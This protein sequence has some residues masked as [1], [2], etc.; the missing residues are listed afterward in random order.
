MYI[1]NN[2]IFKKSFS[3]LTSFAILL[4]ML[5]LIPAVEVHAA[6]SD[7][8]I[9]GTPLTSAVGSGYP[10]T[11]DD[12]Q[13]ALYITGNIT[14]SISYTGSTGTGS[15]VLQDNISVT[16]DI[17]VNG[18]VRLANG[19]T[20]NGNITTSSFVYVD[21]GATVNGNV[22]TVGKIIINS[23]TVNGT[24][25]SSG[26]Q[27]T[28]NGRV[29][30][31]VLTSGADIDDTNVTAT[32]YRFPHSA[33]NDGSGNLGSISVIDSNIVV[34]GPVQNKIVLFSKTGHPTTVNVQNAGALDG[35]L[36][37]DNLVA[38][39]NVSGSISGGIQVKG[40]NPSLHV[41][42]NVSGDIVVDAISTDANINYSNG[43]LT[44]NIVNNSHLADVAISLSATINGN[45]S[46]S[47]D[48]T[49]HGG[50][51]NGSVT[52]TGGTITM[53]IGS[54]VS[55][56][57]T[58]NLVRYSD[59][60]VDVGVVLADTLVYDRY[61]PVD[62]TTG[63][64]GT[65]QTTAPTGGYIYLT[66]GSS[67]DVLT[68]NNANLAPA[69]NNIWNSDPLNIHLQGTNTVYDVIASDSV[70]ITADANGVLN[71]GYFDMLGQILSINSGTVNALARGNTS[72][73]VTANAI[74]IH[75]GTITSQSQAS[76]P[77][78]SVKPMISAPAG[79]ALQIMEGAT[80]PGTATAESA[81]YHLSQY[82][83]VSISVPPTPVPTPTPTPTPSTGTTTTET[84]NPAISPQTGVYTN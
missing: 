60:T 22:T 78:F 25:E 13:N 84:Y 51:V 3:I 29:N 61:Y 69:S 45:I 52:S 67:G 33:V 66:T 5:C 76:Q 26:L 28:N 49:I 20:L 79:T 73:A 46:A 9:N 35:G 75:G 44:G 77:A 47:G 72:S 50:K 68:M 16:G 18:N 4:A 53:F 1:Q 21:P 38:T 14:G 31:V 12:T 7:F 17:N 37:I 54:K 23:G 32:G 43:T 36:I 58:G 71:L 70:T 34:T 10:Y 64:L 2:K 55:G 19:A 62:S 82:A 11:Y 6:Y 74:N 15:V 41:N 42:G 57:I 8:S 65:M 27:I 83:S 56:A 59:V 63:A 80:A 39:V 81:N 40:Q 30:N 24:A 48:I